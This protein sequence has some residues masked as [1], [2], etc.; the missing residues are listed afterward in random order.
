MP[1]SLHAAFVPTCRQLI[2][3]TLGLIDKAEAHCTA[4]GIEPATFLGLRV[5]ADM[6]P[7]AFQWKSV[8]IH[9]AG[10]I[11]GVRAGRFSPDRSDPGADFETHRTRLI[12][13]DAVLAA[14][15]PDEMEAWIGRDMAF[16]AGERRVDYDADQFLLSFSLPNAHFH[17]T[18]GY[19]IL[20]AQGLTLGKRDYMGA[21]RHRG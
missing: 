21:V 8:A 6:L 5:I 11:H 12:E 2:G 19:A 18:T 20:R 3:S 15:D 9:S 16:V 14:I 1:I 13:A 10:A 17:V 7:L 4:K